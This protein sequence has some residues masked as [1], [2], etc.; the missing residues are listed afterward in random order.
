MIAINLNALEEFPVAIL[1][2]GEDGDAPIVQS[3]NWQLVVADADGVRR[4]ARAQASTGTE[5]LNLDAADETVPG[6]EGEAEEAF[7]V[8][9]RYVVVS[10]AAYLAS[11]NVLSGGFA[12]APFDPAAAGSG[13]DAEQ[14]LLLIGERDALRSDVAVAVDILGRER[15][16]AA[17]FGP[18]AGLFDA[19]KLYIDDPIKAQ[20]AASNAR[21][22]LALAFG[23]MTLAQQQDAF[24]LLT[25]E[26]GLEIDAEDAA[27][28]IEE[29][30]SGDHDDIAAQ[31]RNHLQ[32]NSDFF[33]FFD[34][35]NIKTA[36]D[37]GA[38]LVIAG[39]EFYANAVK[40]VL[41]R[42]FPGIEKG[43]EAVEDLEEKLQRLSDPEIKPSDVAAVLRELGYDISDEEAES[44]VQ[45]IQYSI[46]L[47]KAQADRGTGATAT[48]IGQSADGAWA[49]FD[50]A[51]IEKQ[52][53]SAL[54]ILVAEV[55]KVDG[56]KICSIIGGGLCEG[57]N[58]TTTLAQAGGVV[59][60]LGPF[61][62]YEDAVR[63][64]CDNIVPGTARQ[65]AII[66][67]IADMRFDGNW[68]AIYNAP[69]CD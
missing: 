16:V 35:R 9:A 46:D 42:Q 67:A 33:D 29:L 44:F 69:A 21:Q 57:A 2:A 6:D 13:D 25:N 8:L 4:S 10:H 41:A 52:R 58:A 61:E 32:N 34:L 31:A 50:M 59:K 56:I 3:G 1:W 19:L 64:F 27:T 62:T 48:P 54:G 11:L 30:D 65:A 5:A 51:P 20:Q 12:S 37:E 66:G 18:S 63:A 47:L 17:S 23:R 68:H 39:S 45:T 53:G 43:W 40:K 22:D 24:E 26:R 28:F 55:D 36:H 7:E 49:V 38:K 60:V 15:L 14:L